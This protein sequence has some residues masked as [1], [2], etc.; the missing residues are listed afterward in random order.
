MGEFARIANTRWLNLP[1]FSLLTSIVIIQWRRKQNP[2]VLGHRQISYSERSAF[3]KGKKELTSALLQDRIVYFNSVDFNGDQF[4][5]DE[6]AAAGYLP[7]SLKPDFSIAEKGVASMVVQDIPRMIIDGED[8]LLRALVK[9]SSARTTAKNM[10]DAKSATN[11]ADEIVWSCPKKAWLFNHLTGKSV[12]ILAGSNRPDELRSFFSKLPDAPA[13]AFANLDEQPGSQQYN[14]GID[15]RLETRDASNTTTTMGNSALNRNANRNAIV[16][17]VES[18]LSLASAGSLD[19]FFAED[20]LS[21]DVVSTETDPTGD[22]VVQE[23][24]VNLFWTTAAMKAAVLRRELSTLE[25]QRDPEATSPNLQSLVSKNATSD[26][27]GD[28]DDEDAGVD[29]NLPTPHSLVVVNNAANVGLNGHTKDPAASAP[30]ALQAKEAELLAQL[31]DVTHSLLAMKQSAQ[32]I[33]R[34][35]MDQSMADGSEGRLSLALQVDLASRAEEHL[36]EIRSVEITEFP[37]DSDETYEI[38]MERMAEEFG[39]WFNDEY[40]W[41]PGDVKDFP[42]IEGDSNDDLESVSWEDEL[43]Q[44]DRD[45]AGFLD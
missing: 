45:W 43:A 23:L 5:S 18:S 13:G 22:L 10:L 28:Y 29:W 41:S 7:G 21:D 30:S 19:S 39:D 11:S 31:R 12:E 34:R 40:N 25:K 26:Q 38:A 36:R 32:R 33:T 3:A 16:Q 44:I 24:L 17:T 27:T 37:P 14:G 6:A 15:K 4:L 35:L 1:R 20:P 42:V 9:Y 8:A 2:M